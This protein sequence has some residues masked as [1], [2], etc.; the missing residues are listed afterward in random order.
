MLLRDRL[1]HALARRDQQV[2]ILLL[3]LDDFKSVN[4]TSGHQVG[5]ALLV[6]VAD[7]IDSS[8]RGRTPSRAWAATSSPS[9]WSTTRP[10][11]APRELAE[12]VLAA[13][14]APITAGGRS[15]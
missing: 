11:R 9:S 4:D 14:A 1:E 10:S 7:A 5:D 6:A 15:G 13:I 2:A 3:D 12:R 8:V